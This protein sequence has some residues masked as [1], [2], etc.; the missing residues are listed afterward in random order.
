MYVNSYGQ[1]PTRFQDKGP[2]LYSFDVD[3]K[4]AALRDNNLGPLEFFDH[5]DDD[6]DF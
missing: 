5:G 6:D 1:L 2:D 4:A 3:P